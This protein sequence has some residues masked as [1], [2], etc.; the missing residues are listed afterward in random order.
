MCIHVCVHT[1]NSRSI[2][3]GKVLGKEGDIHKGSQGRHKGMS[4]GTNNQ[5]VKTELVN[6]LTQGS[7]Q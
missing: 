4:L 6:I 3:R 2:V 1:E 5:A 7:L